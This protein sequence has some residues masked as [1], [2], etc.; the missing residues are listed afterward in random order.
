MH[1]RP[2]SRCEL[3]LSTAPVNVLTRP[4]V[5][6]HLR[7]ACRILGR[8]FE[9]TFPGQ[10]RRAVGAFVVLRIIS[11]SIATPEFLRAELE[12]VNKD[13]RRALV[14]I[15]RLIQVRRSILPDPCSTHGSLNDPSHPQ[16]LT[17]DVV[18]LGSKKEEALS[19]FRSKENADRMATFLDAIQVRPCS[20]RSLMRS[21]PSDGPLLPD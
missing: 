6:S 17:N 13:G 8:S 3:A 21:E 5:S 20:P 1:L 14:D 11:P 4:T 15:S 10:G 2:T 19:R 12:N 7:Y 9:N 16:N 18:G